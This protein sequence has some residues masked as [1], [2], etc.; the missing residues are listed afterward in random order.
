MAAIPEELTGARN[1]RPGYLLGPAAD[2]ALL[3]GGGA[4]VVLLTWL[5]WPAGRETTGLLT[6]TLVLANVINHPH[7]AHSY[8]LFY[9]GFAAKAFGDQLPASLRTRYLLAGVAAPT[10]L[11]LFFAYCVWARDA[12]LLGMAANAMFLLVGWHYVKQGYGMLMVDAALKRNFFTPAQKQRLLFN[13]YACW[14]TSWL[15]INHTLVRHDYWGLSYYAIP[16]PAWLLALACAA[17]LIT[18]L[19]IVPALHGKLSR[20]QEGPRLISGVAAYATSLYLWLLVRHP[21]V[22][23]IVPALHSMQYLAVVWRYRWNLE[24]DRTELGILRGTSPSQ[25]FALF[26]A[27]GIA[28]GYLGFWALPSWLGAVVPYDKEAFGGSLFVYIFWISINIHHYFLDNVMWR[29][30]NPDTARYLFRR[31]L[32]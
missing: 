11:M 31:L 1:D 7:F 27:I 3:G 4:I 30:D 5:L 25:R 17:T 24:Q 32:S 21:A 8:Q 19:R 16:V 28:M 9:G 14:L 10:V 2:F 22:I 12:A 29:K 23:L 26:I 20:P 13:A 18:T 6:G 15:L